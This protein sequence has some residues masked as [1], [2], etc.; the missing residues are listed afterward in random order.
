MTH[1]RRSSDGRRHRARLVADLDHIAASRHL[2]HD[3]D[4]SEAR[5]RLQDAVRDAVATV[6]TDKQR[7]V[8]EAYFFE[9]LS[10]G[11]IARRLGVTQQVVQKRIYGDERGG[12]SVGGALR[13]LREALAPL[14]SPPVPS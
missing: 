11:E 5:L 8:V 2:Y 10:Q 7:E 4:T 14:V 3:D 6:L 9:G 1:E 12:R 13:K